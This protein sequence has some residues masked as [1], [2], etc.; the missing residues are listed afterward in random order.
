MRSFG[1]LRLSRP[2]MSSSKQFSQRNSV[3][4]TRTNN[5]KFRIGFSHRTRTGPHPSGIHF[6]VAYI[7][8]ARGR[9][10]RSSG[11]QAVCVWPRKYK[12]ITSWW[13]RQVSQIGACRT[14]LNRIPYA[15]E[16]KTS[17][18][19]LLQ[20]HPLQHCVM[21]FTKSP[22]LGNLFIIMAWTARYRR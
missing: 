11:R 1:R 10:T 7:I 2:L 18:Q 4:R 15:G 22:G 16:E 13:F 8:S 19:L 9:R 21:F 20:L 5:N 3:S 14:I 12:E 17:L 6:Y